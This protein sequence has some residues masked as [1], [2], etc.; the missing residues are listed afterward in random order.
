MYQEIEVNVL[1]RRGKTECC[2]KLRMYQEFTI[3]DH[4]YRAQKRGTNKVRDIG[5]LYNVL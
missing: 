4:L 5:M 3:S 2:F 1:D